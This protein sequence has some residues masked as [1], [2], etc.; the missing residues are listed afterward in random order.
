MGYLDYWR[1]YFWLVDKSTEEK[2][3]RQMKT[4]ITI[5]I[6]LVAV[7]CGQ[8]ETQRLEE[9][10]LTQEYETEF[11]MSEDENKR[12]EAEIESNK[13]K[14]LKAE[15]DK[16]KKEPPTNPTD[17]NTTKAKPVKEQA[18]ELT[19]EGKV[20]GTYEGKKDGFTF[21][22]VL[23]ENGIVEFYNNGEKEEDDGKWKIIDGELHANDGI[24]VGVLRKNKDNSITYI[25]RIKDSKREEVP[26]E[27]QVPL[28]KI[29]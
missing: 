10:K 16:T 11:Q 28:K 29:K 24:S 1:W 19:L 8:T 13:L 25:A 12:L 9:E 21:R 22:V 3:R 15:T 26:K 23:L 7:G 18:R 14:A 4:L 27:Y 2:E 6:M 5:L 17:Q 20:V